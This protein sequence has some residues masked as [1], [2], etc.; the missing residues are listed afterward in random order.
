MV[1]R[2]NWRE[3]KEK[4]RSDSFVLGNRKWISLWLKEMAI[5]FDNF[6]QPQTLFPP[7]AFCILLSSTTRNFPKWGSVVE[8]KWGLKADKQGW[9]AWSSDIKNEGTQ[10]RGTIRE[11]PGVGNSR[12]N[13]GNALPFLVSPPHP[14][15][16]AGLYCNL[17][18]KVL[19]KQGHEVRGK[20]EI[21]TVYL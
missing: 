17:R 7:M 10:L 15:G 6:Y 11:T 16:R 14:S 8:S 13:P 5:F 20:R 19:R 4:A 2:N 9:D 12:R 21:C 18:R 3:Q 1:S